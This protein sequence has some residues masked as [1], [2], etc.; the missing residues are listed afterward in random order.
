MVA[1]PEP[2]VSAIE[3]RTHPAHVSYI[4]RTRENYL[5]EGFN[6]P[7][8]WSFNTSTPFTPLPK[9]LRELKVGLVTTAAPFQ[10]DKGDQG[11]YAEYNNDAKFDRVYTLPNEPAPDLRISHIGYDRKNTIPEDI[12]AYFPLALMQAFAAE[13]RVGSIPGRFYGAPT[14]RSQIRTVERDAPEIL[15]LMRQDG[16]EAAVLVAV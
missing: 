1:S 2:P 9:P 8:R 11:P 6:N 4:D 14:L 12:N 10:P 15:D 7:Y 3:G 13:G 16:V 5:R